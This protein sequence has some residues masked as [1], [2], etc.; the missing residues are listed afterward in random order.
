MATRSKK[1][2]KIK[3]DQPTEE[4]ALNDAVAKVKKLSYSTFEGT[5]EL[6]L[7]L[8]LPK[9]AD[10]KSLKGSVSLPHS[11]GNKEVKIAVFCKPE[12]EAAAKEAGAQFYNL[13]QLVK[14]VKAGKIEFDVAIA[15]PDVMPEIAMLGKE[16][17]PRGLMPNPKTGT[18]TEDIAAVVTEY[19][20]GKINFKCD[21]SGNMHFPIGKISMEDAQIAENAMA[22][23]AAAGEVVGKRPAQLITKAHLAPTMGP[24]VKVKFN[25]ED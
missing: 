18:V 17:G 25:F 14:D 5:V 12:N 6:H 7:T 20:K 24:S 13:A 19:M 16:L 11:T 21:D 22:A 3:K 10:V 23:V 9:D 8:K 1:Y 2:Q 15:T 4:F